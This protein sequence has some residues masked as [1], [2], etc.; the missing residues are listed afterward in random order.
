MQ[1]VV[2]IIRRSREGAWIEIKP[3]YVALIQEVSRSR[4]GAWIEM[5][6]MRLKL[7]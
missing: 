3:S 4:E 5:I 1:A 7:T 2:L 6:T